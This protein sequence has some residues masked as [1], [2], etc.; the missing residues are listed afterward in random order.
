MYIARNKIMETGYDVETIVKGLQESGLVILQ[1]L[2]SKEEARFYIER[3]DNQLED[4]I[5]KSDYCGNNNNQVLD[6]YFQEDP[7]LLSLIYQE[8]TDKVM[9]RMI[10]D[11]YVLISPSARNRRLMQKE[12]GSKTSGIGW[13][14]DARFIGGQGIRP[15][16][17]YMSIICLDDFGKKNGATHYIPN[18]HLRYKRPEDRDAELPF[19]YMQAK[20]GDM[21]IFDTAL[22]HRVGEASEDSRWGVFNTYGPWFMKPYHRFS[23]MFSQEDAA[24]FS[25]IIRQLLHFDSL[26][27]KDH[28]ESMI[29]LR[30]VRER[31]G[32]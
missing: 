20:Q 7:E 12:F 24:T 28:N 18:S 2:F 8:I 3:L 13:H 14:T 17:S 31:V 15:S 29:T 26:P 4:R 11:D 25:P 32:G 9:R 23:E 30:R 22:W 5:Q 16:L 10:D 27:P 21:V 6:N 1:N 19:E